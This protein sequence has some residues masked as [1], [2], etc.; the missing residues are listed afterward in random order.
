MLGLGNSIVR[1]NYHKET[2]FTNYSVAFDGTGDYIDTG[3]T[4]QS[5]FRDSFSV[6]LWVKVID[7]ISE[8][9]Q[10]FFGSSNSDDTD[11]IILSVKNIGPSTGKLQ[12]FFE[13]N[14]DFLLFESDAAMFVDGVNSWK[15]LVITLT[16][17]GSGNATPVLYVDGSAIA[18]TIYNQIAEV[19]SEAFTTSD[20]LYIGALNNN[21][22]LA[23]TVTGNIDD[24][25]I[26]SVALDADAVAAIYNS[27]SPTDLTQDSGNYDNSSSLVGYWKMEEGT[28]TT[29]ADSSTNSNTGT[30]SGDPQWDTLTP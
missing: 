13:G 17:S 24:F 3:T 10:A 19:K 28:G 15:H 20:N 22:S 23:Q 4:F 26:W 8:V 5:T 29:V 11:Q 27:G 16:N 7:G 12:F 9:H 18:A 1:V 25:A 30:L 6:S 2:G 14:N 21:G